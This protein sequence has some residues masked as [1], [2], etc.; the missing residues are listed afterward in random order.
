MSFSIEKEITNECIMPYIRFGTGDKVL[1]ILPGISIQNILMA[2]PAIEKQYELF[3][4]DFTVYLFERRENMPNNYSVYDMADDTAKTMRE[5]ELCNACVFGVS[6][7]G[8][9]AMIIAAEYPELVSKL[10]LGS[11]AAVITKE[12]KEVFNEWLRYAEKCDAKQLCLS[13]GEKVYSAEIFAQYKD[14][15]ISMAKTVSEN[16]LKRFI[17]LVKGTEGFCARERMSIIKCPLLAIGDTTDK[18]LGA[19]AT[20]QIAALQKDN[21]CFEMYMYSGYGHAAYDTAPDYAKRLY[22]FFNK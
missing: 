7:G 14:A 11:S 3:C 4:K 18:V 17:T 13:F 6:Q 1:V 16:D 9:I 22:N 5:L 2:A 15:F 21:S 10:A 8:M 19:D 20:P 12:S